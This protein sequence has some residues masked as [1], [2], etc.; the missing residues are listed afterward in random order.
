[1]RVICACRGPAGRDR[2]WTY[3]SVLLRQSG[4]STDYRKHTFRGASVSW[5]CN[6][7]RKRREEFHCTGLPRNPGRSGVIR[8]KKSKIQHNTLHCKR[9]RRYRYW[10]DA[11]CGYNRSG[12]RC[13]Y[14]LYRRKC[15]QVHG[16]NAKLQRYVREGSTCLVRTQQ[17]KSCDGRNIQ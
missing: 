9:Q 13:H 5:Y 3:R 6:E 2:R 15:K 8:Y 11:A 12:R 10:S 14:T 7:R 17:H 1:M 4:R 16:R